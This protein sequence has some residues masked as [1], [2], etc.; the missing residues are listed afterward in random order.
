P[1][2]SGI[3]TL[4][5]VP[6]EATGAVIV[7]DPRTYKIVNR[8]RVGSTPEHITPDWGLGKLY[9][10]TT[11][12]EHLAV[13][14]P[15][16]GRLTGTIHVEYPYNLYFS[17]DGRLAIDVV[18]R[19]TSSLPQL[20]IYDRATWHLRTTIRIPGAGANHLDLSANGRYAYLSTEYSGDLVR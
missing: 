5:Y 7:I 9:V 19:R 6:D 17:L 13:I 3:P 16:T 11:F 10:N 18:D 8:Y 15:R 2:V 4:V 14:D 12:G 20:Y 1:V